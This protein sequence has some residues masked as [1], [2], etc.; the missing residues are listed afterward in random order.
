MDAA[1]N[2]NFTDIHIFSHGWNNVFGDAVGLYRNFW[3][4]YFAVRDRFALNDSGR[5]RPLIAGVIWPSTALVSDDEQTPA[6]AGSDDAEIEELA[7]D[8]PEA[9]AK[10]LRET[11]AAGRDLTRE[12]ALEIARLLLPVYDRP[13]PDGFAAAVPA[14]ATD[15]VTPE[16]LVDLWLKTQTKKSGRFD[17]VSGEIKPLPDDN[18]DPLAGPAAAG[19]FDVLNPKNIVRVA[20]VFQMKDRAGRV[21]ATGVSSMLH[22]L[23]AQ[24]QIPVHLLG[25]SYGGRVVLSALCGRQQP[26]KVRSVLLLQPAVNYLCFARDA[27]G[28]GRPGGYRSALD[29]VEQAIFTTF[30]S[31]DFPLNKTFHFA[32]RRDRDL[33]EAIIAA[34]ELAPSRYAAL[35]GFGPGGLLP[36][37]F[38]VVPIHAPSEK[39]TVPAAGV[40]IVAL[41]GS[42]NKIRGHGDVHNEFTAWAHLNLV[43]P[44]AI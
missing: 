22:D 23:L 4:E 19:I 32:V 41:D 17:D 29:R 8:L 18:F 2:G 40:K 44:E 27:D 39:Y 11:H 30:S 6:F 20:T 13:E 12:E 26:R 31:H 37:E 1:R 43:S 38:S 3:T 34:P 5:Y 7:S 21:G 16:E 15:P 28:A 9:S 14:S 35:G 10:R 33:G 24:T 42:D 25:H 36:G